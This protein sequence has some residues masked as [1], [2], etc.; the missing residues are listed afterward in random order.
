[1]SMGTLYGWIVVIFAFLVMIRV[2]V[3]TPR[4]FTT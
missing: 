3:A 4:T 2:G 1:M